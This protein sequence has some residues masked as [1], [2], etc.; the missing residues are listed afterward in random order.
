M[1]LL[2]GISVSASFGHVAFMLS[3][4]AF[5]EPDILQLR[6][7]SVAA[8]AATLV[9]TYWHPVGRPLWLPFGW[10]IV[11]MLING[12]HIYSILSKRKQ[13]ESLPKQAVDLWRAVFGA[14]ALSA[15]DFDKL[16]Q[17]G[18]WTTFRKGTVLQEEGQPSNSLFLIVRGGADVYKGG[19]QCHALHEHQF[20]GDMGLSSG[21]VLEGPVLGVAHVETNTQTTCLV[22]RRQQIS[23]LMDSSPLI[24]AA[25][26]AAVSEDVVRK[27][28]SPHAAS[29]S[30]HVGELWRARYASILHAVLA[31][32]EL[33][34]QQREQLRQY[35]TTHGISDEAHA[36]LLRENAWSPAEYE[37]GKR[38]ESAPP[39][40]LR[41]AH[42]PSSDLVDGAKKGRRPLGRISGLRQRRIS[43]GEWPGGESVS[44]WD[45]RKQYV[46]A[47]QERLNAFFGTKALEV[48]G[49]F[50]P[51][52]QQAVELFQAQ[53]G[54][55]VCGRVG[56]ATWTALRQ[57]H[58][59]KLES[60]QL[61]SVVRGFDE[62]VELD[63]MLL[64][65][66]LQAV[67]GEEC[68]TADGVYGPRTKKAVQ[69]FLMRHSPDE[70]KHR[71]G[72]AETPTELPAQA[73]AMLRELH[74][75]QLEQKVL[76]ERFLNTPEPVE[77]TVANVRL[78]QLGLIQVLGKKH[79]VVADGVYGERTRVAVEAFQ[80]TFGL[81]IGGDVSEQLAIVLSVLRSEPAR[82]AEPSDQEERERANEREAHMWRANPK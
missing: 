72:D 71:D 62:Q 33:S 76:R 82:Q 2:G 23:E 12:A 27:H 54:L 11:F 74:V 61:L 55:R 68:V 47:V 48:D 8:G 77:D 4:T 73:A 14:H 40:R 6:I 7:L 70:L 3:G 25:V 57:A 43:Y 75:N 78:L 15:V 13:A 46:M 26:R 32:G 34:E 28:S 59:Q 31:P 80:E 69:E 37:E 22:W 19:K 35:R 45:S 5:L 24:A 51:L 50:G 81:P 17:V 56:N 20:I 53:C 58:R 64:Q 41:L 10:N 38:L 18:T 49:E 30:E 16:L 63:V 21:I 44:M 39:S 36:L 9:F 60:D 42:T 79:G 29:K 67:V 65:R 66:R 1:P 52:T